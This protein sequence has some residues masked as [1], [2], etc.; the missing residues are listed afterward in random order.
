VKSQYGAFILVII[1]RD[2]YR[3]L[4]EGNI[5]MDLQEVGRWGTDWIDVAQNRDNWLVLM[6]VV[7]KLQVPQNVENFLTS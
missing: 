1:S 5:K 2:A 6:N 3:N 4:Q 7:M